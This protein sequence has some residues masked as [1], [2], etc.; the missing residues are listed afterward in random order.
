MEYY[1]LE[2]GQKLGPCDAITLIKRAKNGLLTYNSFVSKDLAEEFV[3]A[4]EFYELKK[5]IDE[6]SG[7]A[8]HTS[9]KVLLGSALSEGAEIWSRRVVDFSFILGIILFAGFGLLS[10]LSGMGK[11]NSYFAFVNYLSGTL[12]LTFVFQFFGYALKAKRSHQLALEDIK[13]S[14]LKNTGKYFLLSAVTSAYLLLFALG[15]MA[16]V[17]ATFVFLVIITFIVFAPFL[18]ADENMPLMAAVKKSIS[19]L[20]A[21]GSDNFGVVF[22]LV[23]LNL[24]AALVAAFVAKELIVIVLFVS[25]P[26]TISALAYCYDILFGQSGR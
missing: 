7:F 9:G 18:V 5:L 11:S 24:I 16:G 3:K 6:N 21:A 20:L 19:Q 12:L 2:N 8:N 26:I 13:K 25:L 10:W 23:A 1:V 14:F 15:G 22:A 4:S 17:A